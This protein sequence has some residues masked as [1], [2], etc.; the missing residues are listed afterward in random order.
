MHE[1]RM[2]SEGAGGVDYV[3]LKCPACGRVQRFMHRQE[4]F[5]RVPKNAGCKQCQKPIPI[6]EN[7]LDADPLPMEPGERLL[8]LVNGAWVQV[9]AKKPDYQ[10]GFTTADKV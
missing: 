6:E 3:V 10:T 7:C 9:Q 8:S 1:F 4:C 5:G 2:V